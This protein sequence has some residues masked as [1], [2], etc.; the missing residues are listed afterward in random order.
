MV[1]HHWIQLHSNNVTPPFSE[2][3]S[4][5]FRPVFAT[6]RSKIWCQPW[7]RMARCSSFVPRWAESWGLVDVG[8]FSEHLKL[9]NSGDLAENWRILRADSWDVAWR[10]EASMFAYCSWTDVEIVDLPC[11]LV[12]ELTVISMAIGR[13]IQKKAVEDMEGNRH[14]PSPWLIQP[15]VSCISCTQ[16][17]CPFGFS[18]RKSYGCLHRLWRYSRRT[19]WREGLSFAAGITGP[20]K[21]DVWNTQ[22]PKSRMYGTGNAQ[23]ST[24]QP[25]KL[26]KTNLSVLSCPMVSLAVP[27]ILGKRLFWMGDSP[28]PCCS[29]SGKLQ[30]VARLCSNCGRSDRQS[31]LASTLALPAPAAQQFPY[32][33]EE[34]N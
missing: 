33:F 24:N 34:T 29:K 25:W 16:W 28:S 18:G 2:A 13:M 12:C 17:C 1:D 8:Y 30:V 31:G 15:F 10:F 20:K 5:C 32:G 26:Y 4:G 7:N 21:T 9:Q 14:W 19:S 6:S 22:D 11:L 23:D 27:Y 3:L